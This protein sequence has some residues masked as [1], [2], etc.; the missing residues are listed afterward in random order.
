MKKTQ[1]IEMPWVF[2]GARRGTRTPT[3]CATGS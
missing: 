1:S 3:A 2:D